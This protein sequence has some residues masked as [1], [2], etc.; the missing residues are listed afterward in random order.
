MNPFQKMLFKVVIFL[1][2]ILKITRPESIPVL[3]FNP[4]DQSDVGFV[5]SIL[6]TSIIIIV[7]PT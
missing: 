7:T 1:L 4:A 6:R 2:W 3:Y 5:K